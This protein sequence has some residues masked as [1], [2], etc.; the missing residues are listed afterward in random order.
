MENIKVYAS[1]DL[2]QYKSLMAD[3]HD[4]LARFIRVIQPLAQ[5]YKL[6]PTSLHIF[7]DPGSEMIA[8]NR[9]ASLFLNLRYYEAWRKFIYVVL[10]PM[11]I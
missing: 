8:F 4:A 7:Y 5:V 11:A 3:K 1:R 2:P 6:P 9:N 10:S